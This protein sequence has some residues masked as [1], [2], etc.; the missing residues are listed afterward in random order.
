MFPATL[1]LLLLSGVDVPNTHVSCVSL[2]LPHAM[3]EAARQDMRAYRSS[4]VRPARLLKAL[5]SDRVGELALRITRALRA[6]LGSYRYG[7]SCEAGS[8][9]LDS[10]CLRSPA[11]A[12]MTYVS[13]MTCRQVFLP[14]HQV[15]LRDRDFM[16]WSWQ[17]V[18]F[19][20]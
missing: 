6:S 5:L 4:D 14:A 8:S 18:T 10:G 16:Y 9:P 17:T 1:L 2:E 20:S 15:W 11:Q 19:V 7:P 12:T 13:Y 3:P